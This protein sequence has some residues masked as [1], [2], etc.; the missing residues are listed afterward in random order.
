M[1]WCPGA[2]SLFLLSYYVAARQCQTLTAQTATGRVGPNGCKVV[3]LLGPG[4]GSSPAGVAFKL[5]SCKQCCISIETREIGCGNKK[6]RLRKQARLARWMCIIIVPVLRLQDMLLAMRI[7]GLC[8]Y[9]GWLG[10]ILI[11]WQ[12]PP[13]KSPGMIEQS[14]HCL[15]MS[16]AISSICYRRCTQQCRHAVSLEPL[17]VFGA[18][19]R[20][21]TACST[22]PRCAPGGRV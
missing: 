2:A 22:R 3:N 17:G 6:R 18:C 20:C 5:A 16:P 7:S 8:I 1:P 21:G 12:M 13:H 9:D 4:V 19:E 11:A 15:T 14:S 10:C